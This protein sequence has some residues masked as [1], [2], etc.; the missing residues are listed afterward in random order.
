MLDALHQPARNTALRDTI[1]ESARTFRVAAWL[2]WQIESNWADRVRW[3]RKGLLKIPLEDVNWARD[4]L[5][6]I[7]RPALSQHEIDHDR[8][9]ADEHR[10]KDQKAPER[11]AP[12]LPDAGNRLSGRVERSGTCRIERMHQ[13]S[14]QGSARSN[15]PRVSASV[16]STAP[17]MPA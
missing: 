1:R 6:D 7:E 16:R 9:L 13:L 4:G 17:Y 15:R 11:G 14:F 12:E 3:S 8:D 10:D 5:A 2:G